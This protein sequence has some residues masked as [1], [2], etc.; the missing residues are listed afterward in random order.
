VLPEAEAI[1]ALPLSALILC[2]LGEVALVDGKL[3]EARSR[4]DNALEIIE[5]IDDRGLESEACRHLATLEKLQGHPQL[6]RELAERALDVARKSGQREH[7]AQALLT[8]GDVLSTSLYDATDHADGANT[9]L[10]ASVAYAKAIDVLR[11]I[12]NE[13]QL[14]KALYSFGR[15]K[16]ETG[17]LADGT[18][19]LRDAIATFTKLGLTRRSLDTEKLLATLH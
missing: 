1:G 4:L 5:D 9:A 17:A 6:A 15:Y 13:A 19:M 12:G 3:E 16:A 7:E 2:N 10:D 8:L 18:D 14:G 11:T